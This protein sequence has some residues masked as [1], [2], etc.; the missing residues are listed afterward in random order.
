MNG[1]LGSR[2][3]DI[4]GGD[5]F[6]FSSW[7]PKLRALNSINSLASAPSTLPSTSIKAGKFGNHCLI[8]LP[9]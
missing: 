3:N 8:S 9:R 1:E 6:T 5:R 4:D 7:I 2:L